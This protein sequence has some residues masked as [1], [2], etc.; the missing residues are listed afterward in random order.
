MTQVQIGNQ[1]VGDGQPVFVA[2]EIGINHNGDLEMAKKLID[3]AVE[4]GCQAVKFQKRTPEL[5]VPDSMKDV[6]R[7]TPWG[8]IS[9]LDYRHKVEFGQREYEEIDSYCRERGIQ[10]FVSCWDTE[11]I[12]F[13]E[14]FEPVAYK[15]ASASLTDHKL[16]SR[17]ADTERTLVMSTGMSTWDEVDAAIALLRSNPLIIAH[18]TSTYPCPP[19]E[20]NLRLI[21]SLKDRYDFPVGYSGHEVGLQTTCATVAMGASYIERHITLD[22]SLWGSDQSASVEPGGLRRMV[23]DIRVIEEALG[24]GI[25]RVYDSEKKQLN[26]L[27]RRSSV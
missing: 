2:A 11:S 26:R 4:A 27:R 20:L 14:Q 19:A 6:M 7:E 15:I 5:A 18:T 8:F 10:W 25:K 16:L 13:M 17:L 12:D 9:Y 1:I 21:G 3:V 23:R 22:R 24:D